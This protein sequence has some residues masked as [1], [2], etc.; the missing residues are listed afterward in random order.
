MKIHEKE[1]F[2][3]Y[4]ITILYLFTYFVRDEK[5]KIKLLT[6]MANFMFMFFEII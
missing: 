1:I 2:F 5:L 4:A 3:N 6:V